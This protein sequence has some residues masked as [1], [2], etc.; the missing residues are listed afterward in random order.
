MWIEML[1]YAAHTY[2]HVNH[3]RQL[4]QYGREFLSIIWVM[5]SYRV[6]QEVIKEE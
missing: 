5:G 3:V 1:L 6:I 4:G 2:R